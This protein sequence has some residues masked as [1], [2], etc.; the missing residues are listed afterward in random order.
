MERFF[1]IFYTVS[2]KSN[3]S[4]HIHSSTAYRDKDYPNCKDVTENLSKTIPGF[5][6][7]C[8]TNIIEVTVEDYYSFI[9]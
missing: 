5:D 8:L 7:C 3:P 9:Q 1:I 6:Y 4:V 2:L